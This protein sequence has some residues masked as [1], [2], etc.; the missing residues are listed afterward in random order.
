M[1]G[2]VKRAALRGLV[3]YAMPMATNVRI[4][5]EPIDF[6]RGF[7]VMSYTYG[8][9]NIA[10]GISH[11]R[12]MPCGMPHTWHLAYGVR[13]VIYMAYG[14]GISHIWRMACIKTYQTDPEEW[15]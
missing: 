8:L 9:W 2:G 11:V 1:G 5:F 4:V 10:C 13:H 12:R 14:I 6:T 15:F 7:S 3:G